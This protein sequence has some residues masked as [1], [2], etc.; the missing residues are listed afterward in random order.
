MEDEASVVLHRRVEFGE[1]A[2]EFGDNV[3][4]LVQTTT[5][6]VGM[7]SFEVGEVGAAIE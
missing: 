3:E 2:N 6:D 4:I 1:G 7:Y 5:I